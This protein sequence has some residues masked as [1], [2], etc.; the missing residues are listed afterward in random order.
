MDQRRLWENKWASRV[1]E[2]R[3]VHASKQSPAREWGRGTRFSHALLG[4]RESE[5]G[6]RPWPETEQVSA[7]S[8]GPQPRSHS[9]SEVMC[10]C[11]SHGPRTWET[12]RLGRPE[13]RR[14]A[15]GHSLPVLQGP[16]WIIFRNP[17]FG[18]PQRASR[19]H[20][21]WAVQTLCPPFHRG[22]EKEACSVYAARTRKSYSL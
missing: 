18:A 16:N 13:T 11:D 10:D 8:Q 14:R 12:Q 5:E 22:G 19:E 20:S 2:G 4:P 1:W 7:P 6:E 17:R 3:G 21:R 15:W 9:L